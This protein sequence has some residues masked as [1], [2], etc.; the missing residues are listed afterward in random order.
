MIHVATGLRR[1][2]LVMLLA[3]IF[4]LS[5]Q[6]FVPVY[7]GQEADDLILVKFVENISLAERDAVIRQ[8]NG[9]LVRWIAP[10]HTAQIKLGAQQDGND[11]AVVGLSSP[12]VIS[13][14][15]DE[16]VRGL[17]PVVEARMYTENSPHSTIPPSPVQVNDPDYNN[18]QR[19]YA[20]QL[21]NTSNAWRYH[22]GNSQVII[23]VLDSGV[24][25][26]HP[27][28]AGRVLSGYDFVNND[29]DAT[30][31][32]GHGTHIAGIIAANVNNGIGSAGICPG[33]SI[34]PVK[35]LDSG[36]VGTWAN[37]AAGIVYAVDQGAKIINLSLGGNSNTQIIQDAVNYAVQKGVLIIAAAGNSRTET[38]FY[39]AALDA[40]IAVS[41]TRQD[42]TRWSLSNF[43]NWIDI[44]APGY[45]IFS[46]Y[47]DLSNFYGGYT[48]MSGTSMASPHVAGV[49]GLLM[50]QKLDRT[51][52]EVRNLLLTSAKDLGAAGYDPEFG[53]GRL[54]A[55]AA[56][57]AGAPKP[58]AESALGGIVWDDSNVDG[59]WTADE[60]AG[61]AFVTINVIN[62]DNELV[63]TTSIN[64]SGEWY[65]DNLYAGLYTVRAEVGSALMLTTQPEFTI[66]L[67]ESQ[68]IMNLNFGT[69]SVESANL[70]RVFVPAITRD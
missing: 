57:V 69:V 15:A 24:N 37:V 56:L 53:H 66:T 46:T 12:W 67:P 52:E 58:K 27:D 65:V 2:F 59:M 13:A 11:N 54:D 45:A 5:M 25:A 3:L 60:K 14:E 32:H 22:M 34:L 36:N 30:D 20:P 62:A 50:S 51:P 1:T 43:G 8:M 40:V 7:A 31:D 47:N 42:D 41:A 44:S 23:A 29:A 18:T 63:A 49:A 9:E 38:P 48:F 21:L 17:P 68:K 16:Y 4:W 64:G 70:Y 33:C 55:S 39:P 61:G 26:L 10:I 6:I 19:V 35:V 28:L